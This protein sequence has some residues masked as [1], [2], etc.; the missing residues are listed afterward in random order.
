[1]GNLFSKSDKKLSQISD[2]EIAAYMRSQGIVRQDND[3]LYDAQKQSIQLLLEELKY[4]PAYKYFAN[5]YTDKDLTNLEAYTMYKLARVMNGNSMSSY[6]IAM[7]TLKVPKYSN[8][9]IIN[10]SEKPIEVNP[11]DAKY[12]YTE[13]VTGTALVDAVQFIGS[14]EHIKRIYQNYK[15]GRAYIVSN[16]DAKFGYPLQHKIVEPDFGN[17]GIGGCLQGIHLFAS[18]KAALKYAGAKGFIADLVWSPIITPEYYKSRDVDFKLHEMHDDTKI[19]DQ[20]LN[21]IKNES[22]K[23]SHK[24]HVQ[25]IKEELDKSLVSVELNEQNGGLITPNEAKK[26]F[27]KEAVLNNEPQYDLS[28]MFC[29]NYLA[30]GIYKNMRTVV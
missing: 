1:M 28:D 13:C 30:N 7:L 27:D 14:A 25:E 21:E 9:V 17:K 2:E 8:K 12:A 20:D 6:V 3:Q 5:P 10:G 19:R 11:M 4:T 23:E 26:S 16:F 15:D 29:T 24:K 18:Q 22:R